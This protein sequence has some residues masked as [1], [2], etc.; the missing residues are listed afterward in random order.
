MLHTVRVRLYF[1]VFIVKE[2]LGGL[3]VGFVCYCWPP[4]SLVYTWYIFRLLYKL[5]PQ[6]LMY[7]SGSPWWSSGHP[8][9]LLA[10]VLEFDSLRGVFFFFFSK[11]H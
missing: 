2:Y 8:Q 11:T 4:I 7:M 3:D 9:I 6:H 1:R 10:L 5:I